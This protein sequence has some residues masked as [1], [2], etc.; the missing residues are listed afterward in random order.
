MLGDLYEAGERGTLPGVPDLRLVCPKFVISLR[1]HGWLKPGLQ[2]TLLRQ[3]VVG[4]L[5]VSVIGFTKFKIRS[6]DDICNTVLQKVYSPRAYQV[7]PEDQPRGITWC[8]DPERPERDMSARLVL[9][10]ERR[11]ST[12]HHKILAYGFSNTRAVLWVASK[13]KP[14]GLV[15]LQLYF[16]Q[17]WKQAPC[18]PW[19]TDRWVIDTILL[20]SNISKLFHTSQFT[21]E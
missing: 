8:P 11:P 3:L 14:N 12:I 2:A 16:H 15:S 1:C 17:F 4:D 6:S 20:V 13:P 7:S 18:H 5:V 9:D 21:S 10:C 19:R